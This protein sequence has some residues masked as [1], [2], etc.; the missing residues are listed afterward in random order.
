MLKRDLRDGLL[1][2]AGC[3]CASSVCIEIEKKKETCRWM[4][5]RLRCWSKLGFVFA[6]KS[7]NT[8]LSKC[9]SSGLWCSQQI[10]LLPDYKL[11][12]LVL[13]VQQM[14][15]YI[16]MYQWNASCLMIVTYL[17]CNEIFW[18]MYLGVPA[19]NLFDSCSSFCRPSAAPSLLSRLISDAD[20]VF[21]T[22]LLFILFEQPLGCF[23]LLSFV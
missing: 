23:L 14:Y 6:A 5:S 21:V 7:G 2:L 12:A 22:L 4:K 18:D 11:L 8:V 17:K 13:Q 19:L 20:S 16:Y 9:A 15:I 3:T 10:V 1:S